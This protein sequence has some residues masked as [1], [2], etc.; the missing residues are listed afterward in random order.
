MVVGGCQNFQF[1]DKIPCFSEAI[2]LCL[3]FCMGFCIASLVLSNDMKIS[4]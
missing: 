2:E 1:F 3:K 4:P